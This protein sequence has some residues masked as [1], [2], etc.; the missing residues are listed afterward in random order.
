MGKTQSKEN[1]V[2][3][4]VKEHSE[5]LKKLENLTLSKKI[6]ELA[7]ENEALKSIAKTQKITQA[8]IEKRVGSETSHISKEKIE[9]FV[10]EMLANPDINITYIPDSVEKQIYVN[11]FA[12]VLN[13][14][15]NM[16]DTT[17][18]DFL[19]HKVKIQILSE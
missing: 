16:S 7:K 9:E 3:N 14:L 17:S 19:G 18:I 10:N 12:M 4:T 5:T 15:S 8:M 2:A 11:I 6:E 13:F 1:E